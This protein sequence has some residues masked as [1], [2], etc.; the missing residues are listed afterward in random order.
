MDL[1]KKIELKLEQ[2]LALE[3]Y[4][5]VRI[6]LSGIKRK[7]LQ[8]MIAR[9]DDQGITLEDCEKVSH[10]SSLLLDQLDVISDAYDLEVSSPGIDRPL[11]KPS[12]FVK[13]KGNPVKVNTVILVKG[14]KRHEGQLVDANQEGI[15]LESDQHFEDGTQTI[16]ISYADIRSAKLNF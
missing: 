3:G 1:L 4:E 5:I 7:I 9:Q 14:R 11:T 10:L 8:I 6:Q 13:F 12:H 16:T 15:T 2:S